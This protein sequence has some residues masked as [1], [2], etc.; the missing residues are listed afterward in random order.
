MIIS[1]NTQSGRSMVELMGYMAVVITVVAAVGNMVANAFDEYKYS[2]AYTQL[3][4]LVNSFVRASAID[5]G[6]AD[7]VDNKE[8]LNL[9]PSSYK[10]VDGHYYHI[11]GG[12]MN[13]DGTEQLT[14]TYD[15]LS[16]KQCV[17]LALKD[18]ENN[19]NVD[20]YAIII[21]DTSWYWPVY[22]SNVENS[23]PVKRS[24]VAG[25]GENNGQCRGDNNTIK[26]IF[27]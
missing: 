23:L 18:W 6:Y 25:T 27:N 24:S 1:R 15:N 11:F 3:N 9:I 4:D 8:E 5:D 20:L 13:V 2:K 19:R 12:E 14:I 22:T 21:N 17:E 16:K 10:N 7:V 26:W